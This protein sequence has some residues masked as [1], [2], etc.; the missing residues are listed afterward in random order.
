MRLHGSERSKAGGSGRKLAS[1]RSSG[2]VLQR[3][4]QTCPA[5][6]VQLRAV[7][8]QPEIVAGTWIK[9]RA[10]EGVITE[11][12]ARESLTRLD[13]LWDD[14][15]PVEQARI[16][17]LLVERVDIGTKGMNVWLRMDGLAGLARE[18]ST[19]VGQVA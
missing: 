12:E 1:F 11:A 13:P 7:F 2:A 19:D 17:T 14:F 18:M 5:G 16:V 3:C 9:A 10:Q 8:R 15:F 6:I 4:G